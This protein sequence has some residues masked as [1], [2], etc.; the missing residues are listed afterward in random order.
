MAI[1]DYPRNKTND[2]NLI[3]GNIVDV[4]EKNENGE[5]NCIE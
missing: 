5:K 4:I 1:E 2:M 3:T